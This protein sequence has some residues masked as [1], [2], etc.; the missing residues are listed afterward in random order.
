MEK[1]LC[2]W[3]G[4]QRA[5]SMPQARIGIHLALKNIL[6]NKREVIL[7]PYTIADV[8]NM[9]IS[10]GGRPVFADIDK[11]TCNVSVKTMEPLIGHNTGA[12]L[13]THLHG[14]ACDMPSI[15]DLAENHDIPVLEDAAQAF[16]TEINNQKVGTFGKAGIYSFGLYKNITSF[17]GG[18][19]VSN[20]QEL[21]D[22]IQPQIRNY[23]TFER[24]RLLK[25]VTMAA[26][27]DISTW[28]PLFKSIVF[29]IF[30]FGH[31]KD[32]RM[33]NRFV[34]TEL[35]ESLHEQL[36]PYLLR[37]MSAPQARILIKSLPKVSDNAKQRIA[38][39]HQYAEGLDGLS[40]LTLPPL[41]KDKTHTYTY[42][43]IQYR[44]R[45]SLLRHLMANCC[46]ITKQHLKNT[47]D[48]DSFS[49][50][51]RDCPV[52]RQVANETI[53]LPTY[54]GYPEQNIQQNIASIRTFFN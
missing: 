1:A 32:I 36:P 53:L 34:E 37:K 54:P 16:G 19:L 14:L 28:P 5:L 11:Q 52:A 3:T 49:Q 39:A 22:T 33:I 27:T 31:L 12:L 48:I 7:S 38:V 18:A 23:P 13:V 17:F 21:M 40:E 43:P 9:V 10:A 42:Y 20:D 46:D 47:A 15:V 6:K 26:I 45:T 4:S 25:K 29:W 8:V 35:D 41:R 24:T 44:D 51:Y 50:Y 2:E 30:Q